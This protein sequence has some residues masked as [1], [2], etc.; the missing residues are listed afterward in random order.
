MGKMYSVQFNAVGV[1]AAQDFFEV[2]AASTC[3]VI[4]HGWELGQASD[5]GDAQAEGLR[6][7]LVRGHTTSGSGGSAP[8]PAALSSNVTAAASAT[9]ANNTTIASA[10]TAVTLFATAWNIQ[11]GHVMWFTPECRPRIAP[12]E[13]IVLRSPNTPADSITISGTLFF[14]EI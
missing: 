2:T 14:E 6:L 3:S 4:I 8:T 13:R 7:L 11:A 1:T 12:S 5:Y 10:G 9:E